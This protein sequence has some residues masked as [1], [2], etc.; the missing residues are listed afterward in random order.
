MDILET[1]A[2][3]SPA[4]EFQVVADNWDDYDFFFVHIKPTDSK[5]E[6]GDYEAKAGII[7]SV[8]MALPA[9]L[10]LKPDVMIITGDHSTPASLRSHSW[11]PVPTL[12]HAPAAHLPDMATSFGERAAQQGGLGH[13]EAGDIMP[14]ALAHAMRL[15]KFGA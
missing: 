4:D 3:F 6:D 5:G 12:L 15:E 8:D 9:L 7:E 2:H 13:F 14:L 1:H 10:D 11:H